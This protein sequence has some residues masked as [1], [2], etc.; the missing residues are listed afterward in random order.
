LLPT[1]MRSRFPMPRKL[2]D[3]SLM[4]MVLLSWSP[5]PFPVPTHLLI[6]TRSQL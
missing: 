4:T 2:E 3:W 6:R 5:F 1:V